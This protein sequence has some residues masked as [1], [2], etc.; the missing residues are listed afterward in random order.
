MFVLLYPPNIARIANKRFEIHC[1]FYNQ[2][3]S[4]TKAADY[5]KFYY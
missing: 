2:K 5:A 1:P 3:Q 4:E